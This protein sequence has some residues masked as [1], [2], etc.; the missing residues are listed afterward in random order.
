MAESCCRQKKKHAE[1]SDF[2]NYLCHFASHT[3]GKEVL[4]RHECV[5]ALQCATRKSDSENAK[6]L[7][8]AFWRGFEQAG[9][10]CTSWTGQRRDGVGQP[11]DCPGEIVALNSRSRSRLISAGPLAARVRTWHHRCIAV[12]GHFFAARA[13]FRRHFRRLRGTGRQLKGDHDC[14]QRDCPEFGCLAQHN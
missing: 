12:P 11:Y 6:D 4:R 5:P 8:R 13:L 14:R 1:S 2:R 7:R 9:S 3:R 10:D